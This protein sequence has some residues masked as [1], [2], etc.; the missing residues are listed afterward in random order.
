MVQYIQRYNT[1]IVILTVKYQYRLTVLY[2][3]TK[4]VLNTIHTKTVI[5]YIL[6][7]YYT[8]YYNCTCITVL[9]YTY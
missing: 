4:T 8:L 1:G 6:I 3:T 9:Y 5:L 7:L 2:T